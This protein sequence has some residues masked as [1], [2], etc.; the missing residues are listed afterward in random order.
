MPKFMWSI[1]VYTALAW[2]FA[3]IMVLVIPPVSYIQIVGFLV[4]LYVGI[5]GL[6]SIPFYFIYRKRLP[7]FMDQKVLFK[8]SSKWPAFISFGIVGILFL[9]AFNLI[10]LLNTGLF[11][12]L[13]VGIFFQIKGRK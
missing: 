5:N 8:M 7:N 1:I 13:Y 9:K 11:A 6:L 2:V 10:N 3:A 12:L 4:I